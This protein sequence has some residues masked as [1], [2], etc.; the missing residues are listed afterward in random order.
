MDKRKKMVALFIV[1]NAGYTEMVMEIAHDNGVQG[2]TILNARGGVHH[3]SILGMTIDTEKKIIL[4]AVENNVAIKVMDAMK[5]KA[6]LESPARSICFTMPI[7][8]TVG[9]V[10]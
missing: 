8:Q 10:N 3:E 2:A 9:L 7:N 6:G 1:A 5:K 4:A